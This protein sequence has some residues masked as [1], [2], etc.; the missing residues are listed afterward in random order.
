MRVSHRR[1]LACFCALGVVLAGA[2]RA[3]ADEPE[4]VP[5]VEVDDPV[6][7]FGT[8]EQGTVVE[9]VF[10]LRNTGRAA[11]RVDHVKGTCACTVGVAT[12][13]AIVPG[14]EAWVTVQLDTGRL[15]GHTTKT[16]TIYTNDPA[17]PTVPVTLTG[18]VLV[19]VVVRPTPLYFGHVARGTVVRRELAIASGRPGG[20]AAIVGVDTGDPHLKASIEPAADGTGQRVVV[21]LSAADLPPGRFNDELVLHTTSERQPTVPVKV[22]G[23]IDADL[24]DHG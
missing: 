22:F 10:K 12:G 1:R 18:A 3:A 11:L 20:V 24:A 4:P 17:T 21:E 6:H 14:D 13:E 23:T 2:L 7:D 9:H 5:R 15:A 8:V 19:D 16:A